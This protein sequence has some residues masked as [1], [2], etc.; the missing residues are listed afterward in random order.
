MS[1]PDLE[2]AQ[3][4]LTLLDETAEVWTFQTFDDLKERKDDALARVLHGT[5]DQH[6]SQLADLNKRGAGVFV[7]VNETDGKGRKAGNITRIRAVWQ[8][9]D[10]EGKPLPLEPHIVVETSPDKHHR[11]ILVDGMTP[12]QHG[13]VMRVMVKNYGSD[14]NAKDVARVMRLPGFDHRKQAPHRGRI[15]HESGA[16][17]YTAAEVLAAFGVSQAASTKTAAVSSGAKEIVTPETVKELRDAL[18]HLSADGREQWIAMGNAL[19]G[20]GNVGRELWIEWMMTSPKYQPGDEA[21]WDTLKGER[22]SYKAVFARAQANG[23][24]NPLAGGSTPPVASEPTVRLV[25]LEPQSDDAPSFVLD[26]LLPRNVVT[27]LSAHGGAGKT[28]LAIAIAAHVA[29]GRSFAGFKIEAPERA[30]YVSLEDRPGI[31]RHRLLRIIEHFDLDHT[32]INRNLSLVD[33]TRMDGGLAHE[34]TVDGA[35]TLREAKDYALLTRLCA[36][37]GLIVIDNASDALNANEN[38]RMLVRMFVRGM[39]GRLAEDNNASVLLLAHIDKQSAKF[40]G[41][42]N[43]YSGSTAW[44][45]SARS[46]LALVERDGVLELTHEKSNYAARAESVRMEFSQRGVLAP[47]ARPEPRL[48]SINGQTLAIDH[49]PKPEA[50]LACIRSAIERGETIYTSETGP[51]AAFTVCRELPDFPPAIRTKAAFHSAMRQLEREGRVV[52][53]LFKNQQRKL[54]ERFALP[55]S[56]LSAPAAPSAPIQPSG[57]KGRRA[58]P[59]RPSL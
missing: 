20:L 15:V 10:G 9:D 4:F 25:P 22:T 18:A 2:A 52:R 11:Y 28:T 6:A 46:R 45:N 3:R 47:A 50:L 49:D 7:T 13:A 31:I 29:A 21:E 51:S 54:K 48:L 58:R 42:G 34:A 53:E 59:L 16:R 41:Q 23:W 5:L 12:D 33:A 56:A 39:L 1:A 24:V 19:Y 35:A 37:H 17:P 57:R 55:G 14:Q 36:G 30:V 43:N 40:G 44:H 32:L 26:P 27:L 38:A 8:E